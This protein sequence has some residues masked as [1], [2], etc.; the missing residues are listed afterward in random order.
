MPLAVVYELQTYNL[1]SY[2]FK[3]HNNHQ[4]NHYSPYFIDEVPEILTDQITCPGSSSKHKQKWNLDC[5]LSQTWSRAVAIG[6]S[7]TTSLGKNAMVLGPT[8]LYQRLPHPSLGP[9]NINTS[10]LG[11]PQNGNRKSSNPATVQGHEHTARLIF[12]CTRLGV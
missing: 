5:G 1:H 4:V 8:Q 9:Q 12:W 10:F 11:I 7:T 3:P 6:K 2:I